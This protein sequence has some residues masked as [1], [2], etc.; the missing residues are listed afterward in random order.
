MIKFISG[1]FD[2]KVAFLDSKEGVGF[3]GLTKKISPFTYSYF[4]EN[5]Y[6]YTRKEDRFIRYDSVDAFRW[7][8]FYGDDNL[9]KVE[10]MLV[11]PEV[12]KDKTKIVKELI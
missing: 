8:A 7:E 6:I 11:N 5:N 4:D 9:N 3:S 1:N 10:L 12:I 2:D